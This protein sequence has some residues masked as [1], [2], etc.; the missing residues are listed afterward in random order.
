MQRHCIGVSPSHVVVNPS[1]P[2]F[3]FSQSSR[4]ISLIRSVSCSL[5]KGRTRGRVCGVR[6]SILPLEVFPGFSRDFSDFS[7]FFFGNFWRFLGIYWWNFH[8]R[9]GRGI[10]EVSDGNGCCSRCGAQACDFELEMGWCL[11]KHWWAI[12][13][14]TRGWQWNW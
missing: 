4:G 5:L 10:C 12:S 6:S 11:A 7:V 3:H 13:A 8:I 9:L 1:H 2:N 14:D